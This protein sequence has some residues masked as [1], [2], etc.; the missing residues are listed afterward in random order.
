MSRSTIERRDKISQWRL[1]C[2]SFQEPRADRPVFEFERTIMPGSQDRACH[3]ILP[4][5]D[6]AFAT[7]KAGPFQ[8]LWPIEK[9]QSARRKSNR[10]GLATNLLEYFHFQHRSW[11]IDVSNRRSIAD[12]SD[13]PDED[14]V[15][16]A[17]DLT[18]R[19]GWLPTWQLHRGCSKQE[20][21]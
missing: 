9:L 3:C 2:A 14:P 5:E 12:F 6:E 1:G 17:C 21:D 11:P 10:E 13:A 8:M 4:E 18:Q 20:A 15:G 7:S 19:R 16:E